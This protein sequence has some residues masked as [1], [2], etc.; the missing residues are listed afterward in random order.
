MKR[1]GHRRDGGA[2]AN[3]LEA[4]YRDLMARHQALLARMNERARIA[5]ALHRLS[6]FGLERSSSGLALF[7]D[8]KTVV[9]NARW[10]QLASGRTYAGGWYVEDRARRRTY[11]DLS[12]LAASE[13]EQLRGG[14]AVTLHVWR[15]DRSRIVRMRVECVAPAGEEPIGLVLAD[16]VTA[17][18]KRDVEMGELRE[19]MKRREQ[20]S[21]LGR[22][23]AGVAHDLG[24]A[25]NALALRL[26]GAART[27][28]EEG[29]KHLRGVNDAVEM[30]RQ[31]LDRLDRFSGRRSRPLKPTD[32]RPPIRKAVELVGLRP[33]GEK[34]VRGHAVSLVLPRRLPA[35]LGD[36]TEMTNMFVNLLLNARDA[37]PEGGTVTVSA[38]VR[39]EHVIVRI[40]DEGTGFSPHHLERAFE[41]FFTTKGAR[42]SGLGLSLAYGFMEAIGGTIYA[43]N[44]P[45][46]GAELT[47]EFPLGAA[48]AAQTGRRRS[49]Q[50]DVR[51]RRK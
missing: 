30:M 37:M 27:A 23:A 14:D 15:R 5:S 35:V 16:D 29:R 46:G 51:R 18:T 7:R 26:Y 48:S 28:D 34:D 20:M 21:A 31:T 42:G 11:A 3:D 25:L 19:G 24:N 17:E 6:W 33:D 50:L 38:E 22:L 32:L 40:S 13:I 49:R 41:P 10:R 47:L 8:G 12:T 1:N 39:P 43:G 36:A 2:P 9:A 4:R 44:R 45:E